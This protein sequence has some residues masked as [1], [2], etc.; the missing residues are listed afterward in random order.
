MR[1]IITT[2]SRP[3]KQ[4]TLETLPDSLSDRV[5]MWVQHQEAELYNTYYEGVHVLP[6]HICRLGQT[7]QFLVQHYWGEKIA[8]LD[9]DL[10]WYWR[11]DPNDWHLTTPPPER[12]EQ[13]FKE[14]ED[15]LDTYAH[16]GVSGREGQNRE[17]AYAT[18][19]SRYMRALFYNTA[20]WPSGVVMDR[21]DGMSD[22]DTSLQLLRSGRPSLVFY[23]WAQ[24]QKYTQAP[25]GCA[26]YRTHETHSAEVRRMCELHPGLVAAVRKVNRGG[27]KFGVRDE[28]EVQ[29]KRALAW[30]HI[31]GRAWR[32]SDRSTECERRMEAGATHPPDER[33]AGE[34]PER[35]GVGDAGA[36]HHHSL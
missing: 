26:N 10:D 36:G 15:A 13:M 30:D 20:L 25:G 2:L 29:W 8:L 33:P 32:E 24:G 19:C 1:L 11:R 34:Q 4:R 28:V 14:I 6:E 27:G 3:Y 22:F 18:C 31:T 9:D 23:R 35:L 7:R 21:V 16:V 5:E 12:M 17:S